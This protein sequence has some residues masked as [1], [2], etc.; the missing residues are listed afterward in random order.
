[1]KTEAV[2]KMMHLQAKENQGM[3]GSTKRGKEQILP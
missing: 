3:L 1:M 2:V